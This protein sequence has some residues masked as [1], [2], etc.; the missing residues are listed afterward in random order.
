MQISDIHNEALQLLN[1]DSSDYDSAKLMPYTNAGI[2]YVQSLRI[3]ANDPE[4]I[5]QAVT[6]YSSPIT[7][8]TDFFSFVPQKSS[9]PVVL[10]DGKIKT[11]SSSFPQVTFKYSKGISRV[12]SVT[13]TF[14]IPDEY[15]Y[16]VAEYIK[17]ALK[18]DNNNIDVA[19]DLEILNA[20]IQA[21]LKAKGG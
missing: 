16:F 8:P 12:S 7:K 5:A 2:A 21:F 13:D 19:Q 20:D 15:A 10:Q 17:T 9:Y 14:P 1:S 11:T 18:S 6:T 3:A 4:V